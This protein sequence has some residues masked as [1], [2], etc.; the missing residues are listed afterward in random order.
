[1]K[2]KVIDKD[3]N[4][5]MYSVDYKYENVD[6]KELQVKKIHM[7][8]ERWEQDETNYQNQRQ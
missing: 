5:G 7:K 8:K 6:S 1:M 3:E 2:K 4:V